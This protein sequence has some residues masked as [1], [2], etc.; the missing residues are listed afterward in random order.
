MSET[1]RVWN[2]NSCYFDC[3]K[4]SPDNPINC[5]QPFSSATPQWIDVSENYN[6]K[7]INGSI[8][9]E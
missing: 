2:C 6:L 4:T 7:R 5:L 8:E 1:D 3:V 9:N